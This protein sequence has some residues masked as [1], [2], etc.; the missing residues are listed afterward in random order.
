MALTYIYNSDTPQGG[1]QINNTQSPINGNFQDID[2]LM[3]VN[4]VAFNTINDFGKHKFVSYVNQSSDPSTTASEMALY[5][6]SVT[7]DP[8]LSELFYRYPNDGTI[9]QLTGLSETSQ[10]S[11]NT[12]SGAYFNMNGA[13]NTD[14]ELGSP[15]QGYWQYLSNGTLIMTYVI[16]N[17][18]K[19]AT[20]SPYTTTFPPA[21][22]PLDGQAI[23]QFTQPPFFMQVAPYSV[24]YGGTA[25][26][27]N[28]SAEVVSNTEG[29]IWMSG[30]INVNST[31]PAVTVTLIGI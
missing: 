8:N 15:L 20:T 27:A 26:G 7:N 19:T 17:S 24:Q 11:Q 3:A 30:P 16:S 9:V 18:V 13:A 21:I 31:V 29:R 5:S 14:I 22:N 28:Y 4:H 6:K 23:P 12:A 1:Q 10:S 2:T 25:G